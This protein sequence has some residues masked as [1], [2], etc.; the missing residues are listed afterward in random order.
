MLPYR[1]PHFLERSKIAVDGAPV[2]AAPLGKIDHTQTTGSII[3]QMFYS[4]QTR[5][6]ALRP[7]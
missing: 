5:C 7:I 3:E 2:N 1:H 6:F 4:T